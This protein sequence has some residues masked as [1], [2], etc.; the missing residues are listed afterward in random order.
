MVHIMRDMGKVGRGALTM[1]VVGVPKFYPEL[2]PST[3]HGRHRA[4][5]CR[6][7]GRKDFVK[8]GGLLCAYAMPS[9]PL[10]APP[11]RQI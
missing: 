9:S 6:V 7:K 1:N 4:T 3:A 8:E 11:P 10:P 2:P 5:E